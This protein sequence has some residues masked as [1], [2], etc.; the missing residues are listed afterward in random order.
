M[1]NLARVIGF[2]QQFSLKT[3]KNSDG[4]KKVFTDLPE[5]D[6]TISEINADS[7]QI[8]PRDIAFIG[9]TITVGSET[10][11]VAGVIAGNTTNATHFSTS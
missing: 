5:G 2:D 1:E 3:L 10:T 8:L 4:H 6:Y 9:T 11:N 7:A